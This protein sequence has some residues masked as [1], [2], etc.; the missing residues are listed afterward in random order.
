MIAG[1]WD[2]NDRSTAE[3]MGDFYE[4]MKGGKSPAEALRS[5]KLEMLTAPGAYRHPYYWAP[6]QLFTR[7][8]PFSRPSRASR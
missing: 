7:S 8:D 2:V 4:R 6:F 1:L 3:M 5:A